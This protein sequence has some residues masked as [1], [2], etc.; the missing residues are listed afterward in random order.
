VAA[1]EQEFGLDQAR[2][3]LQELTASVVGR[4]GR[5][6]EGFGTAGGGLIQVKAVDG[7]LTSVELDPRAMRLPSQDL[8][9]E[10]AR[11]ANAALDDLA[12]KFPA[13]ASAAGLPTFDPQRLDAQLA[14]AQQ[15]GLLKMR[16]YAES[17]TDA[18]RHLDRR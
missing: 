7:R 2:R 17:I 15:E 8:A 1:D 11:A 12:S 3:E 18:L 16:R 6:H 14:E 10:F 13:A 5:P 4:D 9:Q